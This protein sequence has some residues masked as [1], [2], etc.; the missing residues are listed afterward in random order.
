FLA[1]S[2]THQQGEGPARNNGLPAPEVDFAQHVTEHA[3]FTQALQ[4]IIYA[5]EN[6][7]AYKRKNNGV[8]VNRSQAA[9]SS[10]RVA[11]VQVGIN[12]GSGRPQTC[13]HAY[14]APEHGGVGKP[15]YG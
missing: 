13:Q 9:K 14:K 5:H 1:G 7:V 15:F 4:G 6:A 11:Q 10:G 2:V 12:K 8:G 3:G